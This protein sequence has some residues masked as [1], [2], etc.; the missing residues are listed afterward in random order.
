MMYLTHIT[1]TTGHQSR[2]ERADI[3]DATLALLAPWL[4][5]LL[6]TG[7]TPPLPVAPLAHFSASAAQQD[8][9][10]ILTLFAP[11][12]P[13]TPGQPATAG[14]LI[15]MLTMGVA[16]RSRHAAALWPLL[17]AQHGTVARLREPGTPGLAVVPHPSMPAYRGDI[18]WMADFEACVAWAWIIRKPTL[19]TVK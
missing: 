14:R 5:T 7:D 17:V 13:H 10:L 4:D 8:G 2:S 9:A 16:Q 12:G 3:D 15:P 6:A 11:A 18:A 19:E 1:L